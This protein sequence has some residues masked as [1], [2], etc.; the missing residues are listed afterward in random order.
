MGRAL[1]VLVWTG[2]DADSN[3]LWVVA[4]VSLLFP[5]KEVN[6]ERQ[7]IANGF[8]SSPSIDVEQ[9]DSNPTVSTAL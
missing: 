1:G 6:H 2:A 5:L 9:K 8:S 7:F 4:D 3:N